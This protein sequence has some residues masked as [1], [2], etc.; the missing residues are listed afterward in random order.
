VLKTSLIAAFIFM[1]SGSATYALCTKEPVESF[2]ADFKIASVAKPEIRCGFDE[3]GNV[4]KDPPSFE[5]PGCIIRFEIIK[6]TSGK[7][8]VANKPENGQYS[9]YVNGP[10]CKKK[11]GDHLKTKI[12]SMKTECCGIVESARRNMEADVC[13]MLP[14]PKLVTQPSP[15]LVRCTSADVHWKLSEE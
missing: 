2:S 6:V 1:N 5:Q 9:V 4:L 10:L 3:S 12:E 14:S 11:I 13:K 15:E 7:L 8:S